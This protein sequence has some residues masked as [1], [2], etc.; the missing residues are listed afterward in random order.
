MRWKT[1]SRNTAGQ[2][3][4]CEN[5]WP[6]KKVLFASQR[7]LFSF[8]GAFEKLNSV[9]VFPKVK[10]RYSR[11]DAGG[12][13]DISAVQKTLTYIYLGRLHLEGRDFELI[14]SFCGFCGMPF[15]RRR[16]FPERH[17]THSA[18]SD[19]VF[20]ISRNVITNMEC[21]KFFLFRIVNFMCYCQRTIAS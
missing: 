1:I 5:L 16:L 2:N 17:E 11:G 6:R 18:N 20:E 4:Y 8:Q 7:C 14:R 21:K 13:S 3:M 19:A 9:K 10:L 12:L 15:N